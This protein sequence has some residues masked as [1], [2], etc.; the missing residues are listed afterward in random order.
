MAFRST[1]YL[2]KV[3]HHFGLRSCV[4]VCVIR[5]IW[6]IVWFYFDLPVSTFVWLVVSF[7]YCFSSSM[8]DNV[9]VCQLSSNHNGFIV[10]FIMFLS[11][12]YILPDN[13][14][15]IQPKKTKTKHKVFKIVKQ[16][17]NS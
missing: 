3:K 6:N 12:G 1:K 9:D 4:C 16:K 5:S 13:N 10:D 8:V 15:K 14:N 17:L 7:L 11:F 2:K